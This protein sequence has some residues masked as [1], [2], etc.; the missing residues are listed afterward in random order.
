ML[1]PD[2]SLRS[3]RLNCVA[4]WCFFSYFFYAFFRHA[5]AAAP[6]DLVILLLLNLLYGRVSA[7]FIKRGKNL[8]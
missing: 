2:A 1:P 7:L 5:P 4:T 6:A 3:K 8:F